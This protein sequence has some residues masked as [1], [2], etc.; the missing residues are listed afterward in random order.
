[1]TVQELNSQLLG[2]H[3]EPID[4]FL[5][6]SVVSVIGVWIFLLAGLFGN[7]KPEGYPFGVSKQM[8]S[9]LLMGAGLFNAVMLA[10]KFLL[11]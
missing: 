8:A 1:M 7:Q 2:T 11:L 6:I 9:R 4:F 10:I 5:Y 3:M